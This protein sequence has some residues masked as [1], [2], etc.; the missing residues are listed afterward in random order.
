MS[1]PP[2]FKQSN[3]LF[4]AFSLSVTFLIPNAIEMQSKEFFSN[5]NSSAL[6]ILKSTLSLPASRT[7]FFPS[8]SISS[9]MSDNTTLPDDPTIFENSIARSPVP[10]ATSSTESPDTIWLDSIAAFFHNLWMPRDMTSFIRSYLEATLLKTSPTS[11]DL[12]SFG[13]SL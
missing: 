6:A 13:T 4:K 8:A 2:D 11:L 7:L 5:G 12:S 10:P 1:R 3:I 9:L